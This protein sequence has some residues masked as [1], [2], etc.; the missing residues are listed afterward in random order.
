MRYLVITQ[1]WKKRKLLLNVEKIAKTMT[2]VLGHA[3]TTAVDYTV[4]PNAH[5]LFL[6]LTRL[7]YFI[8]NVTFTCN[9]IKD[10]FDPQ[11]GT[12]IPNPPRLVMAAGLSRPGKSQEG[13]GTGQDRT[14]R[15]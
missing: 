14:K 4:P 3:H 8:F 13:P 1:I 15:P 2:D 9:K 11:L 10:I 7:F 6:G 12:R 5:S